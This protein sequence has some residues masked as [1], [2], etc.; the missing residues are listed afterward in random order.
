M[1]GRAP[2]GQNTQRPCAESHWPGA[3]HDSHAPEPS[4]GPAPRSSSP[5]EVTTDQLVSYKQFR[6]H[7]KVLYTN[8]LG[9][10]FEANL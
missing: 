6:N 9:I 2:P 10:I 5:P 1:G 8:K 3:A 7:L 4:G